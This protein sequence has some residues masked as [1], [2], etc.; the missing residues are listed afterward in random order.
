MRLSSLTTPSRTYNARNHKD[1][2]YSEATY[3]RHMISSTWLFSCCPGTYA[4]FNPLLELWIGALVFRLMSELSTGLCFRTAPHG[5][6]S[7]TLGRGIAAPFWAEN[8]VVED[9]WGGLQRVRITSARW[10]FDALPPEQA[11]ID[12]PATRS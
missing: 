5:D 8:F 7:K 1:G 9:Y 3:R 4:L 6:E 2:A 11:S 10:S 12:R